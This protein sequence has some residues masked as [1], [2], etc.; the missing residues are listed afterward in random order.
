MKTEANLVILPKN[1][2]EVEPPRIWFCCVSGFDSP[3]RLNLHVFYVLG[4]GI[5]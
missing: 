4:D 1:P 5:L 2:V 3:W